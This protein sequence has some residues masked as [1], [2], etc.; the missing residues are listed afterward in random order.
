MIDHPSSDLRGSKGSALRGKRVV[1]CVTSSVALVKAPEI[2]REMLRFGAEVN[3]V[4]SPESKNLIHPNLMEWASGNSVVSSLT[5]KLEHVALGEGSDLILVCPATANVIS[6]IACGIADDPVTSVLSTAMGST[7]PIVIVP[8]M[9]ESMFENPILVENI[10]KLEDLGVIF[11]NPRI[12]EGKAKIA[13]TNMILF[14]VVREIGE[15]SG[16]L[17]DIRVMVTAGP[18]EEKIDPVRSITNSSS[19]KMGIAMAREAAI[20]GAKVT[21]VYGMGRIEPPSYLDVINVKSGG[22]M[23]DT[24]CTELKRNFYRVF[25]SAAAVSD[26]FLDPI[27]KDKIKAKVGSPLNLRLK[28]SPKIINQIKK[29]SPKTFL[30]AFK[31]EYRKSEKILI[32]SGRSL[33]KSSG[34]DLV[35]ANDIGRKGSEFGSEKT[36]VI[37]V[38]RKVTSLRLDTKAKIATRIMDEISKKTL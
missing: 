15:N 32:E 8:A 27:K 33:L 5:G 29:V 10:R 24:V 25:I 3:V 16:T 9:H 11:V 22:E 35:V 14:T 18:T 21:L 4:M 6:K 20:R 36:E 17:K 13:D 2:T 30:V 26:F 19:G 7:K 23:Y 38:G 34:A 28:V 12:E 1:H 37:L 31:A